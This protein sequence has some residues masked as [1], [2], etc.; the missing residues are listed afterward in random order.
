MP[1]GKS[2]K[3]STA[4]ENSVIM[5]MQQQQQKQ[6]QMKPISP[7][8]HR[9]NTNSNASA[10]A[11]VIIFFIIITLM[12]IYFILRNDRSSNALIVNSISAGATPSLTYSGV[13]GS[14]SDSSSLI[15]PNLKVLDIYLTPLTATGWAKFF[16]TMS[17]QPYIKVEILP[18]Y[19]TSHINLYNNNDYITNATNTLV[20]FSREQHTKMGRIITELIPDNVWDTITAADANP[21]GY[22]LKFRTKYSL[23][24]TTW[25]PLPAFITGTTFGF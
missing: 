12:V 14:W 3:K 7:S 18:S 2:L 17:P 21:A 22:T 4:S 19:Q 6:Q 20:L 16:T 5:P 23:D 13:I 15:P 1:R 24:G 11:L 25:V 8:M 9:T 10:I